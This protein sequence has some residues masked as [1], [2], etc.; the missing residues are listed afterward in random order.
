[1]PR[2]SKEEVKAMLGKP[3]AIII[4]VRKSGPLPPGEPKI[5]GA[6]VEEPPQ[7]QSWMGKYP[8]EKTI[9]LYCT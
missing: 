4:D 7:V 1:V 6:L 9:I 8:K 2:I 5:A 3:D